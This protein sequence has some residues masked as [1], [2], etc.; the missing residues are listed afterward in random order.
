MKSPDY[1]SYPSSYSNNHASRSL[2]AQSKAVG[3]AKEKKINEEYEVELPK[4]QWVKNSELTDQLVQEFYL[5]IDGNSS[6]LLRYFVTS[7][8][9]AKTL[10]DAFSWFAYGPEEKL[11]EG[12]L[13]EVEPG[14]KYRVV[15]VV[16]QV[17]EGRFV[18]NYCLLCDPFLYDINPSILADT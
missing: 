12:Q 5:Q 18:F 9:T 11:I 15:K 13:A 10:K 1:K 6:Y 7:G 4:I 14:T 17:Y 8:G 3:K 2:A 16:K